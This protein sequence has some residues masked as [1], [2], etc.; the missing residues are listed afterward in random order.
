MPENMT[1]EKEKMNAY[2][3]QLLNEGENVM[4]EKKET[5]KNPSLFSLEEPQQKD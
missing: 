3:I 1:E 2:L 4:K 5:M